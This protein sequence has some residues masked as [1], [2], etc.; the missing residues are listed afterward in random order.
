VRTAKITDSRFT[1][2]KRKRQR[3]AEPIHNPAVSSI[4]KRLRELRKALKLTQ[5]QIAQATGV[6]QSTLSGIERGET[7]DPISSVLLKLAAFYEVEP[8]WIQTGEG[9]R[10]AVASKDDAETELLLYF[11]ALSPEGQKYLLSRAR[12]LHADEHH[13]KRQGPTPRPPSGDG[14]NRFQ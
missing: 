1:V 9:P 14:D 11:R 8:H 2:N 7:K 12:A 4:G 5:P 10:H 13:S 6:P 3:V